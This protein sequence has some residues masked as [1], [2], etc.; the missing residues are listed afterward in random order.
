MCYSSSTKLTYWILISFYIPNGTGVPFSTMPKLTSENCRTF[1][2]S[3]GYCSERVCVLPHLWIPSKPQYTVV[4]GSVASPQCGTHLSIIS[5]LRLYTSVLTLVAQFDD[6]FL[7]ISYS[8]TF[9]NFFYLEYRAHALNR[10]SYNICAWN[11][12]T[13]RNELCKIN[14]KQIHFVV[15]NYNYKISDC[16][17]R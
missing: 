9:C 1:G 3:G 13:G 4:P 7:S 12:W 6:R 11:N 17:V 14:G 15:I 2:S 10:V 16:C 5:R 8:Q